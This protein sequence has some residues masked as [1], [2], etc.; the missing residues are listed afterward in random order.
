MSVCGQF[1]SCDVRSFTFA[2]AG[3]ENSNLMKAKENDGSKAT[4]VLATAAVFK[5]V[6]DDFEG[7]GGVAFAGD[8]G[9][10][11]TSANS[12]VA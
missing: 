6:A 1:L 10:Y 5:H 3:N 4:D 2:E 8:E 11:A 9:D 12:G 7:L